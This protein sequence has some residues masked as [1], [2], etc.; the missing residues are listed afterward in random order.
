VTRSDP[1]TG[2]L[3]AYRFP[4]EVRADELLL[5][6]PRD[7]DIDLVAPA[8]LDPDVGGEAGLPP[9][10][11]EALRAMLHEQLPGMRERGLLA[12][13]VVEDT[14]AGD[15][16][17]G[18]SLHH[19]DPMRDTVE[20]GY[21]LFL[22]ARG[23]GV[24]TRA[25]GALVDDAFAQG[26]RRVEAHVRPENRASERVLERLGFEREGLRRAFLR[27]RGGYADAAI[28]SRLAEGS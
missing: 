13:Y 23:R 19:F 6:S 10:G 18:C 21:W 2:Q 27:H 15:L 20:I 14:E 28:W 25:V 26:I 4:D 12:A 22:E 8:F 1:T 17:G 16:L 9:V 3:S 5:R 7:G 11:P 24:A